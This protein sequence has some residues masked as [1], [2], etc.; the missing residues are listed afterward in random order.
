MIFNPQYRLFKDLP[1]PAYVTF[2]SPNSFTIA[3]AN[4]GSSY[5]WD[6]TLYYSSDA[7]TWT[8]WDGSSISA[9]SDGE[10][11]NLFFR[12]SNNTRL[13]ATYSGTLSR[14]NVTGSNVNVSGNIENLL[15][16]DTV[17]LGNHPTMADYCFN[18]WLYGN[19]SIVSASELS[20]ASTSLSS[21][22]YNSMFKGC[23]NLVSAPQTLPATT[24]T[25]YCYQSMFQDCSSLTRTPTL[26]A[27]TTASYCYQN[28][29]N[30][31][32]ALTTA[33]ASLPATLLKDYCY[34][35]MFK[36]CSSLVVAP[37]LPA[38][39]IREYC[40]EGMFENCSSL[41]TP[42]STLPATYLY[43]YCYANMFKGCSALLTMPSI[44]GQTVREYCCYYM[45][46]GCSS[47]TTAKALIANGP[48]SVSFVCCYQHM[49]ENCVN[50]ETLPSISLSPDP[51][52]DANWGQYCMGSMFYGCSKVKISATETTEYSRKY[53]YGRTNNYYFYNQMFSGTSGSFVGTPTGN[54][55]YYTSN[56]V[57]TVV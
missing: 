13:G 42:P 32:S 26:P 55:Y 34:Q 5:K 50:L 35:G 27:T 41:T 45:F 16:Y 53:I 8:V 47:L 3:K 14:W 39:N 7:N 21:Y 38:S 22:C 23:S 51:T 44:S 9:V 25:T 31:C 6:G 29:F 18:N 2:S 12:G 19:T 54:R 43:S 46:Y 17:K 15:D 24:A 28:M 33:P 40:Y 20:L 56:A 48:A 37:S 57:N 10:N 30:G 52:Y 11:Y 4:T 36:G 49:F 1:E